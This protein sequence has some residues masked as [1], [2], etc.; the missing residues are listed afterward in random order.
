MNKKII[1][2]KIKKYVFPIITIVAIGSAV[3]MYLQLRTL[4]KNPQEEAKKEALE[5]NELVGKFVLL[6]EGEIPTIATVSDPAALKDQSFFNNAQKGDKVLIYSQAKKAILYRQSINKIIEI[7][8]LNNNENK[9]NIIENPAPTPEP[10][11][12]STSTP[13]KTT[14]VKKK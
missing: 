1:F 12:A 14:T 2:Q 6:P 5:L 8:P 10:A 4:N 3:F 13:K 7:A 11:P 9:T